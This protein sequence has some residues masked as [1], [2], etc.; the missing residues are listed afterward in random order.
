MKT[1]ETLETLSQ[2]DTIT[3]IVDNN[4]RFNLVIRLPVA[5]RDAQALGNILLDTPHGK[6]PLVQ[7]ASIEGSDGPNQIGRDNSRW[8]IVI[9]ANSDGSDMAAIIEQIRTMLANNPLPDGYFVSLEGQFQTPEAASRLI[10]SLS[11]VSRALSFM[12]LYS[13]YK[14]AVL[15]TLIMGNI[16]MALNSRRAVSRC[17]EIRAKLQLRVHSNKMHGTAR[18]SWSR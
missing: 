3:Q 15:A 13:R 16:P 9:A 17:A 6:V 12:R 2:G 8:R 4:K 5:A 14:S 10:A 18:S 7:V 1:L 11:L